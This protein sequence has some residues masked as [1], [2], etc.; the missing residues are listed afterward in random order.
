MLSGHIERSR[1]V[2]ATGS[3]GTPT[4]EPVRHWKRLSAAT[5]PAH[6]TFV[7]NWKI[8]GE[9]DSAGGGRGP[10]YFDFRN[11]LVVMASYSAGF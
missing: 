2:P 7:S 9:A 10:H 8:P 3:A 6:P 5:D 11:G 4:Q 1:A